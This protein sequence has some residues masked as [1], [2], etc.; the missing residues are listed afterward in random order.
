[1]I[2]L[3]KGFLFIH[4]QKTGGNS[5]QNV[6]RD[7]SEDEITSDKSHQDGH[8]MFGLKNE[9]YNIEKHSTLNQY[10]QELEPHIYKK[11]FKF[12]TIRNPYDLL[13]SSYFSRNRGRTT[14][15]RNEFKKLI[16]GV[17]TMREYIVEDS[18]LSK[19]DRKLGLNL[20]PKF[21]PLDGDIDFIIRF[22]HLNDDFKKVCEAI[23]IPFS[24]LPHRNKSTRKHYTEYYDQELIDMVS[25]R[26]HEEI[27]LNN[28]EFGA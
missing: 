27:S 26:F 11:L 6:L 10:K 7:Y 24:P 18:F 16:Q 23:D 4:I 28:Y 9:K 15:D 22:E 21:K 19:I 12:A 5:I 14:W 25:E 13:I 17:S 3:Q 20:S 2:S 1:M 8:E